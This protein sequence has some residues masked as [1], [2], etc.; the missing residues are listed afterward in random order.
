MGQCYSRSLRPGG[1]LLKLAVVDCEVRPEVTAV[2]QR[3]DAAGERET[4]TE[5]YR[6]LNYGFKALWTGSCS[7]TQYNQHWK[8]KKNEDGNAGHDSLDPGNFLPNCSPRK[9]KT[10]KFKMWKDVRLHLTVL[11]HTWRLHSGH[12]IHIVFDLNFN[13]AVKCQAAGSVACLNPL[14]LTWPMPAQYLKTLLATAPWQQVP[15]LATPTPTA[16]GCGRTLGRNTWGQ[17]ERV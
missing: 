1:V 9:P 7:L 16:S 17:R 6:C 15:P 2:T 12:F 8:K 4:Q 10:K 13:F 11:K 5:R 14:Q 3:R